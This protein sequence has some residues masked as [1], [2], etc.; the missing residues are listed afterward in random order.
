MQR[1]Q[2]GFLVRK[3]VQIV[4]DLLTFMQDHGPEYHEGGG[5]NE[6]GE[7]GARDIYLYGFEP[8][9]PFA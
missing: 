9:S 2:K 5:K 1:G 8:V 4:R 6:Y 7:E 3:K